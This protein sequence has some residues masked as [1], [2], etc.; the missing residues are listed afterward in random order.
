ML[1]VPVNFTVIRPS[2]RK[3]GRGCRGPAGAARGV[4]DRSCGRG[5]KGHRDYAWAWAATSSPR[6][7][8]LIRRSL[9]DPADLAFYYCHA[10]EGRPV[11]RRVLIKVDREE[12]AGRRMLRRTERARPSWTSTRSGLWH[13]FTRH[14]VLTM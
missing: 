1:A 7:W 12:M 13:S 4:G 14:T 9:S 3:D 10:P 8:I 6:R 2:G 5:C 11:S